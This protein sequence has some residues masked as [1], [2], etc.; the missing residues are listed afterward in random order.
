[1]FLEIVNP[2]TVLFSSKVDSVT[3]PGKNGEFQMLNN[4][5]PLVSTLT[6][7][8]VKIVLSAK[9]NLAY[10]NLHSAF[11]KLPTDDKILTLKITS[12]VVEVEKNKVIILIN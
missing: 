5:A 8:I 9:N 11:N 7:G 1:M 2:E 10:N 3:V 6:K 12:G 4:H